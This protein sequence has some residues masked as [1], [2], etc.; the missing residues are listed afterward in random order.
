MVGY[1]LKGGARLLP[2]QLSW[3]VTG[4]GQTVRKRS[5]EMIVVRP[6]QLQEEGDAPMPPGEYAIHVSAEG[7]DPKTVHISIKEGQ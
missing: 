7:A 1:A 6:N 2:Q 4:Q 5:G 3:S